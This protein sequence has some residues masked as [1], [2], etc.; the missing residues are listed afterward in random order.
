MKAKWIIFIVVCLVAT[1]ACCLTLVACG[2]DEHVHSYSSEI[3]TPATCGQPGVKTFTCQCGDTYTEAIDATGEHTWDEG[4][5]TEPTCTEDGETLYTCQVCGQTRSDPIACVG[6]H[7][8]DEGV[9]T[10]PTCLED[11]ET[12]YTC[13]VCGQTH[14]D[15]IACVGH[16]DWDEGV[17][18]PATCGEEGE[19][20]YTCSVCG[21]TYSD[22]IEATGAHDWDEGEITNPSTCSTKGT[23]TYTCNQCGQ[24]R[25]EELP[26]ADHDWDEG[27][28]LVDPACDAEGS[29]RYTCQVCNKKKKES[30]PKTAHTLTELARVEPTCDKDGYIQYSCSVCR[31]IV[32]EAIP[33]TGHNLS[34]ARTVAPTCTSQGYDVYSCSVCHGSVNKNFVD[35][36]GHDFDFDSVGEDDYYTMARCTHAGCTEGL[37]RESPETLKKEMVYTFT[38]DDKTRINQLWADMS[39][40]L[41]A[42]DRYD[43]ALHGYVKDSDLYNENKNFEHTYYDVFMNEFYFVTEQ[44]QYAFLDSCVYDDNQHR[45]ISDLISNFRSDLVTNYYSLFRTIY[46]TK[47]RE[48]FFSEEDGWT[49]EDIQT[50]LDYSDTYGGGELAELDKKITSLE[51]RFNQLDKDT[52]VND[53]GK[54]FTELY[55]EFVETENRIAELHGYDNYMDYAYEVVYGREYSVDQTTAIRDYIKTNFGRSHFNAL[56]SASTWY[57]AACEHDK[58]FNAIKGGSSAFNNL[59]INQVI[60]AYFNE[61]SCDTSARPINFFETVNDLFRNGNYWTG[62]AD[63]AFTWWVRAADTPVLYFGPD[64]YSDAFTFVHEFGHY[65]NDIYNGGASMSMDLNETHSQGNELMFTAFLQQYLADKANEYTAE[66]IMAARL[67]DAIQTILLCTAVDEV[68]TIIYSNSYSGSDP[69]ILAIAQDGIQPGEYDALGDAVFDSYG[70]KE[71]SYYWRFVTVNS[72]GYYISYAMSMISSMEVWAKSQSDGFEAAKAAYFKLFTY[73]D[74]EDNAYLDHDGD[75]VALL[76]YAGVLVY[77]GFTSPF[78]EVTYTT[79]GTCLDALCAGATAE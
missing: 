9:V 53:T 29:I 56:K 52:L 25:E 68:E 73:T 79:I 4:V 13:Q 71:Y 20:L 16:H 27:T 58:F 76:D 60:C 43:E 24:H 26:L 57:E 49:E 8:W 17:E 18:T 31:Q 55:T 45:A 66:A 44:Y 34:Y 21:D 32:Y 70:V 12:L 30:I 69:A 51:T 36:L 38:E 72:P 33:S 59:L 10:E 78:D 1:M 50:A 5:V 75:L 65:Y 14:S 40:F 64:S 37:R 6:H 11:G 22:I 77:A 39:A 63:R 19:I 74:E 42:A 41:A 2:D 54:A 7:D 67:V 28:V 15:P 23:K 46:E 35:E 62:N 3:T 48:Y 47:Y 61:M